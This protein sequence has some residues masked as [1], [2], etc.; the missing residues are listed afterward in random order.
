MVLLRGGQLS[1]GV[2][3]N[4]SLSSIPSLNLSKFHLELPQG[5]HIMFCVGNLWNN[6]VS[7]FG[8]VYSLNEPIFLICWAFNCQLL[9]QSG[10]KYR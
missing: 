10:H 2:P 5:S 1:S 4:Y 9:Y 6:I 7:K 3:K 8:R